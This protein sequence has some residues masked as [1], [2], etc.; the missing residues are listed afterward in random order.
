MIASGLSRF[1]NLILLFAGS[2]AVVGKF[3]VPMIVVGL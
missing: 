2:C 1:V 3:L